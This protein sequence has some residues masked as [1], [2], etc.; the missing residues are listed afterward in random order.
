MRKPL[1]ALTTAFA[2]AAS[3]AA[4]AETYQT[5]ACSA[6]GKQ[7]HM[8]YDAEGTVTDA[9]GQKESAANIAARAFAYVAPRLKA[10]ALLSPKGIQS[11]SEV[12]NI[13]LKGKKVSQDFKL[14]D[15]TLLQTKSP[16]PCT[17]VI[18]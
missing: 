14:G 7:V 8:E 12:L 11:F 1:L 2:M 5:T 3:A 4:A 10:E 13:A 18:D 17:P 6:D 9:Q 15:A 16:Q